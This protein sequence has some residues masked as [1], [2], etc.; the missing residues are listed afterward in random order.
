M[1][2]RIPATGEKVGEEGL[3]LNGGFSRFTLGA[4]SV[5]RYAVCTAD[6]AALQS[7]SKSLQKLEK[8]LPR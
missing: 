1:W 4:G 5:A 8:A 7:A 3:G 6:I 2:A